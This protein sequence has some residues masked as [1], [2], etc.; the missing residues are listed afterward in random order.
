VKEE[1]SGNNAKLYV[2]QISRF[3]RVQ[4]STMFHEAA[5]YVKNELAQIGISDIVQEQF[6]SDGSK[7]YW[8]RTTPM[9]WKVSTSCFLRGYSP[10]FAYVQ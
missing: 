3:N 7:K 5:E 8:T 1:L 10:K 4:A 2:A 9:G 6:P